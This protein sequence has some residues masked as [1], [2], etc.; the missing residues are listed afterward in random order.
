[1]LTVDLAMLDLAGSRLLDIGCGGGRHSFEALKRGADV[2]SADI[3]DVILKDV[4]QMVAAMRSKG[5]ITEEVAHACSC[6]NA[7]A[8]PF[9]DDSFEIVIAAEVL[10]H[11][12]P[13]RAALAEMAR[14][15]KPG[16]RIV[17]T[18]PR[19]W[20]ERICWAL[21]KAYTADAGGH[22]R[23]YKHGELRSKLEEAG[24]TI[25][26]CHHAH[27]L[28]SPYWWL[29]CASGLN[30]SFPLVAAYHRL[31]TWQITQRPRAV[32]AIEEVLNPFLGKSV[33]FYARKTGGVRAPN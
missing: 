17:V 25:F 22:V 32:D 13:D 14:V 2:V 21:S 26:D 30:D 20:P 3:D 4:S 8:L 31:L 9:S 5:E 33:A 27:A 1:V 28:H 18:V 19:Y 7:L 10:E 6:T 15:V 29:K 12:R 23:I 24:L 16:G 11:I